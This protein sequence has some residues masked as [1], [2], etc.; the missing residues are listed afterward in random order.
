MH[1]YL[2]V[3]Q[4]QSTGLLYFGKTTCQD[5][6]AYK[7]SGKHWVRHLR[8]HGQNIRT[9][10]LW[11][12]D[13]Q[14]ACTSFATE[15]SEKHHIVE[16]KAWANLVPENGLDGFPVGIKLSEAHK[17]AIGAGSLGKNLGKKHTAEHRA[18][19]RA[20][21]LGKPRPETLGKK[22]SEATRAK[23]GAALRGKKRKPFSE[24]TRV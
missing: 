7:G 17:A 15:F 22:H 14:D 13:D 19:I 24:E 16:S 10:E 18:K 20:A 21:Q 2:Y 23:I 3:K 12:F 5:P 1:I 6:F 4:H 9:V 11:G 8:K